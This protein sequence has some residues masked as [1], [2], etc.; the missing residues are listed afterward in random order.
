MPDVCGLRQWPPVP[1]DFQLASAKGRYW[2]EMSG[3]EE[4]EVGVFILLTLSCQVS[5]SSFYWPWPIALEVV[6][7][8][9]GC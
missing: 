5:W 9:L 2:Q 3:W 7:I 6:A 1:S 8:S 4:R